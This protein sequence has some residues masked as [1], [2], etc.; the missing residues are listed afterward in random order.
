MI[1]RLFRIVEPRLSVWLIPLNHPLLQTIKEAF[2][3]LVL[4]LSLL[5]IADV[6]LGLG[7]IETQ[8]QTLDTLRRYGFQALSVW[9]VISVALRM[10]QASNLPVIMYLFSLTLSTLLVFNASILDVRSLPMALAYVILGFFVLRFMHRWCARRMARLPAFHTPLIVPLIS[11]LMWGLVSFFIHQLGWVNEDTLALSH[12]AILL[13]NSWPILGL[14]NLLIVLFWTF[15][16]HGTNLMAFVMLPVAFYGMTH[17]LLHPGAPLAIAGYAHIIFGNWTVYLALVTLL[18]FYVRSQKLRSIG[19]Q[20]APS[21]VFNVNEHLIFS[22][23]V[24]NPRLFLP[25]V[26]SVLLNTLVYWFALSQAW[27]DALIYISPFTLP[28]PLQVLWA[29]QSLSTLVVWLGLFTI[30]LLILMPPLRHLDR[31]ARINALR[32]KA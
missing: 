31:E 18:K 13:I 23:Q 8:L 9:V 1:E 4:P 19:Q 14:I 30:N 12:G 29:S 20:S 15:G 6:L 2:Q 5:A 22:L 11:G 27:I 10:L 7:G 26:F 21:T 16:Y 25:I 17:N 24:R 32:F 28:L 3:D